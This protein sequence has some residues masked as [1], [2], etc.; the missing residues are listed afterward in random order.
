M[1]K[2]KSGTLMQVSWNH[3][4]TLWEEHTK[5]YFADI[6]QGQDFLVNLIQG[7]NNN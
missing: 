2:I 6:K 7:Y 5:L 4:I 3:M 1:K